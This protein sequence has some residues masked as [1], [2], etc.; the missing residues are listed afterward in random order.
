MHI[1]HVPITSFRWMSA[2]S[3]D[4]AKGTNRSK[5]RAINTQVAPVTGGGEAK[6]LP[7]DSYNNNSL[8][9]ESCSSTI[10]HLA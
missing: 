1:P 8:R 5:K 4:R 9:G 10:N 2:N 7:N 6:L 3:E